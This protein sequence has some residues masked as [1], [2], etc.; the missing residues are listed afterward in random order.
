VSC[1]F[2]AMRI[3]Q[4]R[5][6]TL[7]SFAREKSRSERLSIRGVAYNVRRWGREGGRPLI[8]LHGTQDSSITFQFLVDCLMGDWNIVAP[9]WRGHG[10]SDWVSGGYWFHDFVADLDELTSQ[11]FPGRPIPLVGHSLGGNIAGVYAGLR[12][13]AVSHVVSLDGFGP[14]VNAVPVEV[15]TVL[16]M[17]LDASKHR[18]THPGYASVD[19]A[20]QRLMEANP[21]LMRPEAT[22]LA[23]HSTR[24]ECDGS[25]RWLFDP[26]HRRTIPTFRT[27]EE[28][29]SIWSEVEARVCWL[30]SSD[31]RPNA[32][33]NFPD[34][35]EQRA[36]KMRVAKRMSF[37]DTSHNI[38]HDAPNAVARAIEEFLG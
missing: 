13:S 33:T 2:I 25:R 29:F 24:V 6:D 35:M 5:E 3:E 22:F 23:V 37:E 8:L 10:H 18:R 14:L 12:P 1:Y 11:L 30:A 20:A 21:R 19:D 28:W 26:T 4:R 36:E 31:H 34:V 16:R 9:D 27:I 17:S 38:Q 15:R 32:P 7:C